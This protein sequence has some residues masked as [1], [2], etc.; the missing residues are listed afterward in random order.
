MWQP[1]F[2][3]LSGFKIFP[4]PVTLSPFGTAFVLLGVK[5]GP[6]NTQNMNYQCLTP[7]QILK[8]CGTTETFTHQVWGS[9]H[10][11][12]ISLV[13]SAIK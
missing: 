5:Q 10:N 1:F 8:K 7:Q 9:C 11:G 13:K 2:F 12:L 4:P 3:A 6:K